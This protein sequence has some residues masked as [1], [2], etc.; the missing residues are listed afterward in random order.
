MIKLPELL[1]PAGTLDA[2]KTAILYGADAIYAGLP[3][4]S[5]RARAKITVDEV[6]AGI[7]LAHHA[8]KKVYL[9]FN[10]F[11]HDRDYANMDAV[12]RVINYLRPDALIV[13]DPGIVMWVRE[14]HPDMPIHISTQANI[15]SAQTVKFWQN[16]G[17]S[18][19]VL[20]REVSHAEFKQIRAA[21]PD[22]GLEIFVHGAMCMS[23]SGRC[24]LSNYITGR[25]ANRGAC[26]Q[27]C[28]WKYDVILR[29]R[30]S[31]IEMPI[32][33]DE[34]GAYIMNSRDLCLM[35][36]LADVISSGPNS[37]KIEGRNR[38]EYYV[39]SVVRAYRAA[40]D[41]YAADPDHFDPAPFM[42]ALN[43]LQ[44]RGYTTAF[45]DG[46][47]GPDA[48]DYE[49]TRSTSD[50]MAAGVITATAP[51]SITLELRNEI[52]TGDEIKFILPGT[53]D[54]P[55]VRL[56]RIINAAT[57]MDVPKL[58]AGQRNSIVIPRAWLDAASGDKLVPY[59]LAYRHK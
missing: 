28:R 44:T 41:A 7:D 5:M 38:S 48:H 57:G 23:Y 43:V 31:G 14:N 6:K 39:G 2:F 47:L 8:G 45:F 51:D 37:L 12:S 34:R 13:S 33:E 21:C 50:Y 59:V 42:D 18:L 19:C 32:V 36:R 40:M 25:P 27:L 52:R 49:T 24:L 10:L 26:A 3:G 22:V 30:E 4:F 15:C 53:M 1:A 29:E 54:T 46:P 58:A 55:A 9:A 11:A 16:A 56:P 35:P 20:A 17:A